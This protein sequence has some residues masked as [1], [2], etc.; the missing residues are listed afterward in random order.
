MSESGF[1]K[2]GVLDLVCGD[3]VLSFRDGLL[4]DHRLKDHADH[5]RDVRERQVIGA[6]IN[7]LGEQ[8]FGGAMAKARALVREKEVCS[9]SEAVKVQNSLISEIE[10]LRASLSAENQNVRDLMKELEETRNFRAAS[11]KRLQNALARES[12]LIGRLREAN[13]LACEHHAPNSKNM[14]KCDDCGKE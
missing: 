13:G 4:I 3:Q 12:V 7:A 9:L 2:N 1:L 14:G 5:A 6:L 8:T 10:S 11:E